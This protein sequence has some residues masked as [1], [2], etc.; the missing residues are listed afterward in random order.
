MLDMLPLKNRREVNLI[1]ALGAQYMLK[2]RGRR[3]AT[4][5]VKVNMDS[6]INGFCLVL[7]IYGKIPQN[8]QL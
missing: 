5:K 1:N 6:Y 4:E 3:E 7:C 8:G 2:R